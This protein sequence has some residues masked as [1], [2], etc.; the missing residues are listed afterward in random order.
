[1]GLDNP[2][3]W[4]ANARAKPS[5]LS[6]ERPLILYL[7]ANFFNSFRLGISFIVRVIFYV[8]EINY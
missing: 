5:L 7:V 4:S 1:M 2:A 3:L 8:I 6:L